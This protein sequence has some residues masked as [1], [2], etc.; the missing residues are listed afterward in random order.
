MEK[1]WTFCGPLMPAASGTAVVRDRSAHHPML[2][3]S[4]GWAEIQTR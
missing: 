4:Q 2:A 1:T 3:K